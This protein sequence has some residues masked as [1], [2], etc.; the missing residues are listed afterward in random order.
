MHPVVFWG[1]GSWYHPGKWINKACQFAYAE[2]GARAAEVRND[3]PLTSTDAQRYTIRLYG[4]GHSHG[5]YNKRAAKEIYTWSKCSHPNVVKLLGLAVYRDCLA[6]IS[7][8]ATNGNISS[9]LSNH[10]SADRC[11]LSISICAGLAYLHENNVVH[12]DLKAANVLIADD[13]TPMLTDF[14]N[15]S[16]HSTT[17]Q[18]TETL[19][20]P[21]Y[22]LRWTAPEILRGKSGH[23]TAGDVYSLGMTILEVLTSEVPFPKKTDLSLYGHIVIHKKRPLRPKTIV[24][25]RSIFGN[26]LWSIL[27]SC[28]S[29]E[30]QL[31][32]DSRTV[33]DVL[34]TLWLLAEATDTRQ[35]EGSRGSRGIGCGW[36]RDGRGV[37]L[38]Q[39][40]LRPRLFSVVAYQYVVPLATSMYRKT[41]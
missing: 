38:Y 15:S 2:R 17:L 32:P 37:K 31:R 19:S 1:P 7:P 34:I 41:T 27:T 25:E 35:A 26:M 14:G 33:W 24:P 6:M 16:L 21:G 36:G 3:I 20:Q 28:W 13:G 18:F 4:E 30:P 5:K 9:Y 40:M 23:T 22:S 11:R 10:Q 29:Y 12:G 8:W 39:D